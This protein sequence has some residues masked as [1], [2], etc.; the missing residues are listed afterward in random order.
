MRVNCSTGLC[1][2]YLRNGDD[3]LCNVCGG[4]YSEGADGNCKNGHDVFRNDRAGFRNR[5]R[6]GLT[7]G[8]LQRSGGK[9]DIHR[10]FLKGLI[11][12]G[13]L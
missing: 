11:K 12:K 5:S 9:K 2:E 8:G 1:S 13:Y 6:Q 10:G 7:G 4:F 3:D